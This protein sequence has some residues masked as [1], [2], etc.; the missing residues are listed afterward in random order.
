MASEMILGPLELAVRGGGMMI[1]SDFDKNRS[2]PCSIKRPSITPCPLRL[3]DLPVVMD[4]NIGGEGNSSRLVCYTQGCRPWGC[5]GV[6]WHSQ[7]LADH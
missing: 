7:V 3:L 1:P 2:N 6:P 5:L 4:L